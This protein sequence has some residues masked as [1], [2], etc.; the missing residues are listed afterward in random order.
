V[1]VTEARPEQ[2]SS[3]PSAARPASGVNAVGFFR[4]EF[5]HGEAG[6]RILA[7]IERAGLPHATITVKTPH[8]REKH[9]FTA[10]GDRPSYPTNVVCLNPEHML[11]FAQRGGAELFL[12]RYTVG[13]WCWEASRFPDSFRPAFDLVDEVWVASDYV[14]EI[15]GEATEKPVQ[16]FPMPVELAPPAELTR[17]DVGLPEDRFVF[18]FAFDFFSTLERKN[19]FGLIEAFGR[20]FAPGEGPVLVIKTIN[21]QKQAAELKRLVETAAR[22]PDIRIVDEYVSGGKMRGLVA[23][24]D[25]FISLHRSEGFGFSLAEAMVYERPVIATGYSGNLTFMNEENSYLVGYGLTPIP[26]GIPNYPT[27]ALWADPDLD[28]AAAAMRRV[29][30]QPEEATELGKRGRQTLEAGHSLERTAQ[31]VGGRVAEIEALPPKNRRR[32]SDVERAARFLAVGPSLSWGAPSGRFGRL[33][34]LARRGLMRVLR[35][36]LVRHREWESLIVEALRRLEYIE[37]DRTE[38]LER[39]ECSLS[40]LTDRLDALDVDRRALHRD[41]R[42]S[43]DS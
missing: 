26:A 16:V 40:K 33:G 20:A 10:R 19:P 23:N 34:V 41:V 31:F 5:G 15:V 39:L 13:V 36:Y 29:V 42:H 21:G 27:G 38:R 22:H 24:C 9:P 7:G 11:E 30:E 25:C 43:G 8:H 28:E 12:D 3:E 37:R 14:A 4:A 32:D 18:L 2:D 35:P 6:R 17:A 1:N